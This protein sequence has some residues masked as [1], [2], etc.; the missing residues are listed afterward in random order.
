[1]K[2]RLVVVLGG[3]DW[4]DASVDYIDVAPELD[5]A[6]RKARYDMWYREEYC[7][8]MWSGET[9]HYY[10]FCDWL[11]HRGDATRATVE[12]FFAE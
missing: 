4:T 1:M 2:T 3:G 6:A 8:A 12:E 10:S 11:I 5:L 9:P 7:P